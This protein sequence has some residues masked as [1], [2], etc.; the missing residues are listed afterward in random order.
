MHA[1][2]LWWPRGYPKRGVENVL[3]IIL[4]IVFITAVVAA[5]AGVTWL[6]VRLSPPPNSKKPEA[7]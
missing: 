1:A 4:F 5:A 3:G 7:G 6:V 2:R